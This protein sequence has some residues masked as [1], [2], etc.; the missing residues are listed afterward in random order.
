MDPTLPGIQSPC[1]DV[2]RLDHGYAYCIGC[3]RTIEEIK[4]WSRMTDADKHAVLAA[5]PARRAALGNTGELRL[6]ETPPPP[7]L[8]TD[9]RDGAG[10]DRASTRPGDPDA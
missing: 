6:H 7:I 10:S 9:T 3:L 1:I 5:L 4:R 8:G 2:C